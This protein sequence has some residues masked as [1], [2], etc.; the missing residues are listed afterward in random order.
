M[1]CCQYITLLMQGGFRPISRRQ[2]RSRSRRQASGN[3]R[4]HRPPARES[5]APGAVPGSPPAHLRAG[6]AR[7]RQ[8]HKRSRRSGRPAHPSPQ[9]YQ[10]ARITE[11]RR[12]R[13]VRAPPRHGRSEPA[14]ERGT[15]RLMPLLGLFPQP[16]VASARC[17]APAVNVRAIE[18]AVPSPRRDMR[19][20]TLGPRTSVCAG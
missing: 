17:T 20:S 19:S 2:A 10:S 8:R 5:R 11:T 14:G 7:S 4:R 12:Y 13:S 6:P 1:R 15:N 18:G 3:R 16:T 9:A